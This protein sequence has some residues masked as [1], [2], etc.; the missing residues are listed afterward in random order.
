MAFVDA[1]MTQALVVTFKSLVKEELP[2]QASNL[3]F[4]DDV[5][6]TKGEAHITYK[7]VKRSDGSVELQPLTVMWTDND[8]DY[9]VNIMSDT[10]D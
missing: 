6:R 1:K 8:I 9:S 4:F 2:K 3:P 5:I 7:P 10:D